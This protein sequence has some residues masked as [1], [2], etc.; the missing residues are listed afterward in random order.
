MAT[1]NIR[2]KADVFIY[3]DAEEQK[4]RATP[5]P[6]VTGQADKML[7]FRNLSAQ[8]VTLDVREITG[9]NAHPKIVLGEKD[10]MDLKDWEHVRLRNDGGVWPYSADPQVLGNSGPAVII[11]L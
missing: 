4:L 8:P 5:S 7:V 2:P 1:T 10:S 9:D 11:D 6:F 3:Y